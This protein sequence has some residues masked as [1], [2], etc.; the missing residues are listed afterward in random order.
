M[1]FIPLWTSSVSEKLLSI[2]TGE[3]RCCNMCA[4]RTFTSSSSLDS[5]WSLFSSSF[6]IF[7][8]SC[9]LFSP[10]SFPTFFLPPFKFIILYFFFCLSPLFSIKTL[11]NYLC[12]FISDS[13]FYSLSHSLLLCFVYCRFMLPFFSLL[14]LFI[15]PN[16][17]LSLY[18][19]SPPPSPLVY[20]S[21][22]LP[23]F[24][25]SLSFVFP[26]CPVMKQNSMNSNHNFSFFLFLF[27]KEKVSNFTW[28][29]VEEIL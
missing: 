4:T 25:S 7:S 13:F 28:R 24:L 27:W 12:I 16:N 9:F 5:F 6:Y 11:C 19:L 23:F 26:L 10:S 22:L 15:L 20:R 21:I 1:F 18:F 17:L 29:I 3:S 8:F 14:W 2:C